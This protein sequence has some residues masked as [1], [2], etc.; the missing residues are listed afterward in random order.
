MKASQQQY[1]PQPKPITSYLQSQ[2]EMQNQANSLFTNFGTLHVRAENVKLDAAPAPSLWPLILG[3]D[4]ADVVTAEN[5]QI[6]A[7]GISD[8]FRVSRDQAAP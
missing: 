3:I 2:A 4:V 7:G 6:G 8:T 1:G 5:W